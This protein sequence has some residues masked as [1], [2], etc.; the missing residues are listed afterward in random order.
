ML[1]NEMHFLNVSFNPV[2]LVFYMFRTSYVHL[3][4]CY[5]VHADLYL[6]FSVLILK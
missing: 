6:M 3:Q 2:L 5:I 4:E 1:I